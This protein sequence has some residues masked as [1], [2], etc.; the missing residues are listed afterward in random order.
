MSTGFGED[1]WIDLNGLQPGRIARGKWRILQWMLIAINTPRG[2]LRGLTEDS[3]SRSFGIDLPGFIG[4][5]GTAVA[6]QAIP[7]IVRATWLRDDRIADVAIEATI[8][9]DSEKRVTITLD[10]FVSTADDTEDFA[11]TLS[12]SDASVTLAGV[13]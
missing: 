8:A 9:T 7:G 11:F 5:A 12:T 13:S 1:T 2:T 6:V 4:A 10:C 3:P